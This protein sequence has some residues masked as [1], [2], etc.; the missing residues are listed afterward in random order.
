MPRRNINI[1]ERLDLE[2]HYTII[3]YLKKGL[4][5]LSNLFLKLL[6]KS[7]FIEATFEADIIFDYD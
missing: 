2:S 5:V 1:S 6:L 3:T 4:H 7:T